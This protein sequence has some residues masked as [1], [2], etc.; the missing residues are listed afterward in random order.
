MSQTLQVMTC[1]TGL[2]SISDKIQEKISKWNTQLIIGISKRIPYF[3]LGKHIQTLD[4]CA[5][6][7]IYLKEYPEQPRKSEYLL[8]KKRVDSYQ[9]LKQ[10]WLMKPVKM[11]PFLFLNL[12]MNKIYPYRSSQ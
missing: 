4:F 8:H 5:K 9:A 7:D 11:N 6:C 10:N 2:K 3:Q 1:K 12:V